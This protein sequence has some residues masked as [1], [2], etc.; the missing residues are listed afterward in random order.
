MKKYL[1][2][3]L[4]VV[5]VAGL[6][7]GI[8]RRDLLM[9]LL[10]STTN[11]IKVPHASEPTTT[12]T[13]SDINIE[14]IIP[15]TFTEDLTDSE[16]TQRYMEN[17]QSMELAF[18]AT[19]ITIKADLDEI[20]EAYADYDQSTL[21]VLFAEMEDIYLSTDK[22]YTSA[23]NY[24]TALTDIYNANEELYAALKL[25]SDSLEVILKDKM[26]NV[27]DADYDEARS[28]YSSLKASLATDSGAYVG[29]NLVDSTDLQVAEIEYKYMTS[30]KK[31]VDGNLGSASPD[32][33]ISYIEKMKVSEPSKYSGTVKSELSKYVNDQYNNF[34]SYGGIKLELHN[35]NIAYTGSDPYGTDTYYFNTENTKTELQVLS[36]VKASLMIAQTSFEKVGDYYDAIMEYYKEAEQYRTLPVCGTITLD[37]VEYKMGSLDETADFDFTVN[38][39][40]DA[41]VSWMNLSKFMRAM[42]FPSNSVWQGEELMELSKYS[43]VVETNG[44]GTFYDEV[45]GVYANTIDFEIKTGETQTVEFIGGANKDTITVSEKD[46]PNCFAVLTITQDLIMTAT[47]APV[48]TIST[49]IGSITGAT[50]TTGTSSGT[51]GSGHVNGIT[52]ISGVGNT[53][54]TGDVLTDD[55]STEEDGSQTVIIVQGSVENRKLSDEE[56]NVLTQ[57]AYVCSNPFSD[58]NGH[59][60]Q[61][62]VCRVHSIGAV[63]GKSEGIFDP[64]ADITKAEAMKV[65]TILSEKFNSG[66][67]STATGFLDVSTAEWSYPYLVSAE[68]NDVIRTRDFGPSFF[69]NSVVSRGDLVMYAARAIGLTN[70]DFESSYSD[71]KNSDYFAYAVASMSEKTVDVPYDDTSDAVPV[72]EGY[73]DGTFR[74]NDP[75]TRAEAVAVLY[76]MYLAYTADAAQ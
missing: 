72:I 46:I 47:P 1:Y 29:L 48:G 51:G 20:K 58:M 69:P 16:L 42:V 33:I 56:Q 76:R 62:I 31:Y 8:V 71:V 3:L 10:P 34:M 24:L 17:I 73:E 67:S 32:T 63:S 57:E 23:Y 9:G 66:A 30:I 70:Y 6:A 13:P 60:A 11:S 74:P 59:W 7:F 75:I 26:Q 21:D 41:V 53:G 40:D 45:S 36:E 37:P 65:L 43:F 12:V 44:G 54:S 14:Q 2:V 39:E 50:D 35:Y 68:I 22:T 28:E 5:L 55:V 19:V 49:T 52:P 25:E 38:Y 15:S 4:A 27:I 18:S 64:D 61:D